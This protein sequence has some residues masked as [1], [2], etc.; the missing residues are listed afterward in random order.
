MIFWIVVFIVLS[1]GLCRLDFAQAAPFSF[2]ASLSYPFTASPTGVGL[3]LS[4][5]FS[6]LG[7]LTIVTGSHLL[8]PRE[9]IS[10]VV[11]VN[12]IHLEYTLKGR[13]FE[14]ALG[15]G[16]NRSYVRTPGFEGR[17]GWALYFL[18]PLHQWGENR[19]WVS[20]GMISQPVKAA[21]GTPSLPESMGYLRC[22]VEVAY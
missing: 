18:T 7:P 9:T 16:V 22:G 1:L 15:G 2:R 4:S 14:V 21:G 17:L 19:L 12:F 6:F 5:A 8:I 3:E 13:G 20:G 10:N 11:G